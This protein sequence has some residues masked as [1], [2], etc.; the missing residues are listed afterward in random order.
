MDE[1]L[2]DAAGRPLIPP[3]QRRN[4]L[5]AEARVVPGTSRPRTVPNPTSG[6]VPGR[7]L[8]D[9]S[10]LATRDDHSPIWAK[11]PKH[12]GNQREPFFTIGA[13]A[14]AL[15]RDS[16]TMR[17]WITKGWL[18]AAQYRKKTA[19][20]RARCRCYTRAQIGGLVQLAHEERLLGTKRRNPESTHFPQRAR[21]LFAQLA[22]D[23]RRTT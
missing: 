18:P 6:D 8:P 10:H 23:A 19:D 17:A 1:D 11:H 21:G 9:R 2:F 22:A 13:L 16:N 12:I 14:E 7:T 4:A 3:M 5:A 20:V 15:E